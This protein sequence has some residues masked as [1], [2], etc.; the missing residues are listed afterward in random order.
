M[1][2]ETHNQDLQKGMLRMNTNIENKMRTFKMSETGGTAQVEEVKPKP[3]FG[4]VLMRIEATSI[5]ARDLFMLNGSYPVP[6]GRIPL[7]DASGVIEEVGPG[8]TRFKVGDKVINSFNPSWIGGK[9]REPAKMYHTD[10]DGFLTDYKVLNEQALVKMPEYLDF[11]EAATLPCAAVTAWSAIKGVGAGDT[12]LIQGTGAVSLFALQLAK[13]AGTRVIATTSK[14]DKAK[15]LLEL[16]ASD[17]IN[18]RETPNWG[19]EVKKLTNGQGADYVIEVG[20]A[21]TIAE[22]IKSVAYR[23]MISSVGHLAFNETGMNL[24]D[25]TYSG[26]TL[27]VIGGG[28]RSD[29]EDMIRVMKQHKIHPIIDKVFKFKNALEAISHMESGNY[30]GK[31][32]IEN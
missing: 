18:Y 19:E 31:I 21:G 9:L 13:A 29:L 23:G 14:E 8:V 1:D 28:S 27:R 10:L 26:A 2:G 7:S 4:Q 16:G 12:V 15:R 24:L 17:V 25:F 11:K 20:G 22:S 30:F 6:V 3:A 32:V 5:N